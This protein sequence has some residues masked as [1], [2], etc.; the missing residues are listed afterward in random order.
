MDQKK[1]DE[2]IQELHRIEES[3]DYY[4]ITL[5][6]TKDN[7][8]SWFVYSHWVGWVD[9]KPGRE[10][11][12]ASIVKAH[13]MISHWQN[14]G[15]PYAVVNS[16]ATLSIFLL[17]GGHALIEKN[18]AERFLAEMIKPQSCA[19]DGFRGFINLSSVPKFVLKRAPNPKHRMRIF[20]RDNFR[21]KICG[22]SPNDFVDV[23]L[24]VHHIRPWGRGG[25]TKDDN[26]IT[27]C[28]TCHKGL[29]PHSDLSLFE[30]INPEAFRPD[31]KKSNLKYLQGVQ[32]YR[33]CIKKIDDKKQKTYRKGRKREGSILK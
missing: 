19:S 26:L 13:N 33:D 29:D 2:P 20:K 9:G 5:V 18:V 22:R 8:I 12:E 17:I 28:Q 31:L 15:R 11:R 32:C 25:L 4:A 30:L 23:E 27:I 24:H 6:G 10:I 21:C 7:A 14:I 3:S 16:S 1:T